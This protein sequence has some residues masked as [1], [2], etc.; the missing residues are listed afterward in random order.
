[1]DLGDP[2][3]DGVGFFRRIDVK[4]ITNVRIGRE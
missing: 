4:K 1:M 3:I 2:R